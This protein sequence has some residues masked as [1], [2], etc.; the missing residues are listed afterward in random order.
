M[1]HLEKKTDLSSL[2]RLTDQL[3][4]IWNLTVTQT[5]L[6]KFCHYRDNNAETKL[7]K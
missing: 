6:I 2:D 4:I 3:K 1:S 7:I 5:K